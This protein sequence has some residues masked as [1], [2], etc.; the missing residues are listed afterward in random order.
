VKAFGEVKVDDATS[1]GTDSGPFTLVGLPGIN[2]GQ[3]SPEYMYT[4]HSAVDTLDHV[5]PDLITRDAAFM[6]L[7][8]FWIADRPERLATP[9]PAEQTAR[10]LVEKK[11]DAMLKAFGLWPFGDL[12]TEKKEPGKDKDGGEK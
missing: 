6:A 11:D 1:F 9:W 2:M 3:D 10:M 4:H 7:T 12:G 8:S 5:K